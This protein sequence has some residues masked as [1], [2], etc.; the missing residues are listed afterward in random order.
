MPMRAV[1]PPASTLRDRAMP[2]IRVK[3]GNPH[4]GGHRFALGAEVFA[5]AFG[6]APASAP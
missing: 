4:E 3:K 2:P 1:A 5:G 6:C